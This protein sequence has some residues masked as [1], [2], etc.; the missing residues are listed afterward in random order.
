ML[1]LGHENKSKIK[2]Q[3]CKSKGYKS[4]GYR[5]TLLRQRAVHNSTLSLGAIP[6]EA[7]MLWFVTWM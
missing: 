1:E 7:S 2:I 4:T 6:C 3:E 5:T